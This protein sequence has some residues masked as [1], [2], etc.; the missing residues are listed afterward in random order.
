[1]VHEP[2]DEVML[3]QYLELVGQRSGIHFKN[4]LQLAKTRFLSQEQYVQDLEV[5]FLR[6]KLKARFQSLNGFLQFRQLKLLSSEYLLQ[7]LLYAFKVT[8][9]SRFNELTQFVA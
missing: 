1:M 2:T 3:A 6:K 4:L 9:H 8:F 5:P 7:R